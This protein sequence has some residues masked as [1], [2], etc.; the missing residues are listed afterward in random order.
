MTST[1]LGP[2]AAIDASVSAGLPADLPRISLDPSTAQES[3]V[4]S[5]SK[6]FRS[7]SITAGTHILRVEAAGP[8]VIFAPERL[9]VPVK[10]LQPAMPP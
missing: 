9:N 6:N 8:K 3:S 7:W 2:S 10:W 4:R 5:A 1:P